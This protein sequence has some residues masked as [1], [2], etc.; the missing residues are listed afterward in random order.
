MVAFF[1]CCF[2]FPNPKSVR[3][4]SG[5]LMREKEAK[6]VDAVDFTVGSEMKS[7]EKAAGDFHCFMQSV[8]DFHF[9]DQICP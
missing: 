3:A 2:V 5:M 7:R 9:V 8:Y 4:A 6:L 1:T